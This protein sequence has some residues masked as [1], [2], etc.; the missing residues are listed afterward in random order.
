[1]E[2]HRILGVH[3]T[4]RT[5][6]TS[7]VQTVLSEFGCI[8]KTRIGLHHATDDFCSPNGLLIL[9]CL[10]DKRQFEGLQMRLKDIDGV[11]VQMMIFEHP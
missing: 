10:D 7:M 9:E 5:E 3:I 11:E 8:I 2:K 6:H 4:D 1:M